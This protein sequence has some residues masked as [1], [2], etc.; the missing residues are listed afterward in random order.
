MV[1]ISTLTQAL[2]VTGSLKILMLTFFFLNQQ[3]KYLLAAL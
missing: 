2:G 3:T 1:Q